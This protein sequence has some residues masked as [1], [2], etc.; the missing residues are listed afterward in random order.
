[1]QCRI[2]SINDLAITEVERKFH[3]P[4]DRRP[5]DHSGLT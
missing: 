4:S 1:M 3:W 5:G 2:A